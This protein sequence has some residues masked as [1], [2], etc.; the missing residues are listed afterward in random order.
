MIMKMEE[1]QYV[2]H[3]VVGICQW[4]GR[5]CDAIR[6]NTPVRS[7]CIFRTNYVLSIGLNAMVINSPFITITYT[8]TIDTYHKTNE[9]SPL[10]LFFFC[11]D[12]LQNRSTPISAKISPQPP[13]TD[14]AIIIYNLLIPL[15][16]VLSEGVTVSFMGGDVVLTTPTTNDLVV[17]KWE[18]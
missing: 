1:K 8:T 13:T 4:I 16:S 5:Y 12:L 14:T 15:G 7:R 10:L 17:F 18:E 9:N 3:L 2:P 6:R 11:L